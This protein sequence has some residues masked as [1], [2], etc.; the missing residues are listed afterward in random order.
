MES[1]PAIIIITIM[2]TLCFNNR[3]TIHFVLKNSISPDSRKKSLKISKFYDM[4]NIFVAFL[5]H[6]AF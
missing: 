5:F 1:I 3:F 6:F 4:V 2:L